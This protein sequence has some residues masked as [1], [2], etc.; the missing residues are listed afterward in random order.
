LSCASTGQA[1][2]EN[3]SIPSD[4]LNLDTDTCNLNPSSNPSVISPS[5]D[6]TPPHGEGSPS[7]E[8][9]P[10]KG[11]TRKANR[12][13]PAYSP[14]FE[15]FWKAYPNKRG[16]KEEA[17]AIWSRRL[18]KNTLPPTDYVLES[19]Q[20]LCQDADWMEYPPYATT[21]LNQG[22]WSD[23]EGLKKSP[24][25]PQPAMQKPDPNCSKCK[26][27]GLVPVEKDGKKYMTPCSCRKIGIS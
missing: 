16:G 4:S 25:A 26:G 12:K 21:F 19:V 9:E 15:A 22:R 17:W 14:E 11:P 20:K 5:G 24:L 23:V 7:P 10:K 13:L 2:D 27:E 18:K 8:K 1:S 6:M 3:K